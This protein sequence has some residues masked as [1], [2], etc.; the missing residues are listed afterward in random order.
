MPVLREI[1]LDEPLDASPA[2]A[3]SAAGS[4]KEISL[5]EP[6][7]GEKPVR[8]DLRQQ[9]R[10]KAAERQST[11]RAQEQAIKAPPPDP[12][13]LKMP[14]SVLNG[15][16]APPLDTGA[17]ATQGVPYTREFLMRVQRQMD[18]ATPEKRAELAARTDTLG[19][20]AQEVMR[21]YAAMDKAAAPIEENVGVT[22][23]VRTLDTRREARS[24][25]LAKQGID[26]GYY[27][28][29]GKNLAATGRGD[30][31]GAI[32]ETQADFEE[33]N[34]GQRVWR[35]W[36]SGVVGST[37][38]TLAYAGR[39]SGIA[40]LADIGDSMDRWAQRKMPANPTF[41]DQL[42]N[43]I[44]SSASFYVPG[45]G[46]AR[47]TE[48]LAMLSKTAGKW[49]GA[50]TMAALEAAAEADQVYK[51]LKERGESEDRA[52]GKADS[53]FWQNMVLLG[54]SN[55]LAFFNDLKATHSALRNFGRQFAISAPTEGFQEGAQQVISNVE[56][57]KP[58]TE[59]VAEQALIGGLA[60][61]LMSGGHAALQ[62]RPEVLDANPD[63]LNAYLRSTQPTFHMEHGQPVPAVV[64]PAAYPQR[65]DTSEW[66]AFLAGEQSDQAFRL[67]EL[68]QQ[69]Q[70]QRE[71]DAIAAQSREDL[72][73]TP[74]QQAAR[75]AAAT[76]EEPTAME[77]ALR[78]AGVRP[79]PGT[80]GDLQSILDDPRPLEDIQREQAG[81]AQQ[82]DQ[83]HA[84]QA[85]GTKRAIS[86]TARRLANIG[87][88]AAPMPPTAPAP[89]AVE[90]ELSRAAKEWVAANRRGRSEEWMIG[91]AEANP[92]FNAV[93][94][95]GAS[96]PAHGMAK[97]STLQGGINSLLS[98]L[99]GGIDPSR[100]L[101]YDSLTNPSG[102]L[103]ADSG[104]AG[105]HAYR[106]GPF[107]I[108][109][110]E[111]LNG[112]QP[113]SADIVGVLVNPAHS[114]LAPILQRMF[115]NLVIRDYYGVADV[116][117]ASK[118]PANALENEQPT[119]E[120]VRGTEAPQAAQ[121]LPITIENPKGSVRPV[122]YTPTQ[123]AA[124]A[125]TPAPATPRP[126]TAQPEPGAAGRPE[127]AVRYVPATLN[128]GT[129]GWHIS[130]GDERT[131][132][133]A[134]AA[135]MLQEKTDLR[136]RLLAFVECVTHA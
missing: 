91:A 14:G 108:V 32:Q 54:L 5:D 50:G 40:A 83:Q 96:V 122:D 34:A 74:A 66:D 52:M 114:E 134:K 67:R 88:P 63:N 12:N 101:Y 94:Q 125:Q 39:K 90:A 131:I 43:A 21:Q 92:A 4:F 89:A 7:D 64:P 11:L 77:L 73:L 13:L 33:P 79:M 130:K 93:E 37:G 75:A 62:T 86:D 127:E 60:G 111:G 19:R 123:P 41:A 107:I 95:I 31:F 133:R 49:L 47:G 121:G 132:T 115:P 82:A 53:V 106:D 119:Q 48:A 78:K 99:N 10:Q 104:T 81:Q 29:L 18:A 27:D 16:Q 35:D 23:T 109:F 38:A 8:I 2:S 45:M 55:K 135:K 9:E 112:R 113:T 97:A 3:P 118:A 17:V 136:D 117:S 116:I 51:I 105:G 71:L 59:G 46:V 84:A 110:R 44:G 120:N 126:A 22:P 72:G 70:K 15:T 25:R 76:D 42:V 68:Q 1:S 69:Q 87:R 36:E 103:G 24:G 98:M 129:E 57:D 80:V 61:G 58:V 6:L 100:T 26:T 28:T 65:P 20:A 124:R 85:Q 30:Q 102:N 56:T 128:E